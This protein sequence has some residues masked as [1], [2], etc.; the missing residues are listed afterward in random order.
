MTEN[1]GI[2]ARWQAV[3]LSQEPLGENAFRAVIDT[4]GFAARDIQTKTCE[5]EEPF[6]FMKE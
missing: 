5:K 3:I 4:T 2:G 6:P 1:H